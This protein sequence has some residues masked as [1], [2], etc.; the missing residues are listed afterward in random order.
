[1]VPDNVSSGQDKTDPIIFTIG[2]ALVLLV[3][4]VAIIYAA[5]RKKKP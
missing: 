1:M 4:I 3:L 2:G 5:R